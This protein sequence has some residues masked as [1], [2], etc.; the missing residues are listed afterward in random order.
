MVQLQRV[1]EVRESR[2]NCQGTERFGKEEGFKQIFWKDRFLYRQRSIRFSEVKVYCKGCGTFSGSRDLFYERFSGSKG[3]FLERFPEDFLDMKI[4]LLKVPEVLKSRFTCWRFW[5]VFWSK[6]SWKVSNSLLKGFQKLW[7]QVLISQGS[8][9]FHF[10]KARRLVATC[11]TMI[12]FAKDFLNRFLAFSVFAAWLATMINEWIVYSWL[13][14]FVK[15]TP[16]IFGRTGM[17]RTVTTWAT[18]VPKEVLGAV[19]KNKSDVGWTRN[20]SK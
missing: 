15:L 3:F 6:D 5:N 7:H 9:R 13:L 4:S 11:F 17:T 16:G 10:W 14:Y 1:P 20:R 19:T 2:F 12:C 18:K 8:G